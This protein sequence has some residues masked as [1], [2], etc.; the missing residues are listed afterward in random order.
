[1]QMAINNAMAQFQAGM[2]Q[3]AGANQAAPIGNVNAMMQA[4]PPLQTLPA[5]PGLDARGLS[6]HTH[7]PLLECRS[8][9]C[10][11]K[12]CQACAVH[13]H[14]V[15]ECRKRAFQNPGINQSGYWSETR[16]GSA[17]LKK[18]QQAGAVNAATPSASFPT[19]YQMHQGGAAAAAA[20]QASSQTQTT[21]QNSGTANN[22]AQ[23]TAH[24]GGDGAKQQ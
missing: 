6:W 4:R 19:P 12:F 5:F 1:M 23:R 22:T 18:P 16:A 2:I 9:P 7:S 20:Q 14:T 10:N 3:Q 13:G 15:D 8:F 21:S 24:Q 17:P 11:S